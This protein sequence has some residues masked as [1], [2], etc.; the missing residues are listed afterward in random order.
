MAPPLTSC[1][2]KKVESPTWHL[3]PKCCWPIIQDESCVKCW[4]QLL[5]RRQSFKDFLVR[6][7][8][9]LNKHVFSGHHKVFCCHILGRVVTGTLWM[10][11][12]SG[13]R[14]R[15]NNETLVTGNGAKYICHPVNEY[16]EKISVRLVHLPLKEWFI[17]KQF[18]HFLMVFRYD[19]KWNHRHFLSE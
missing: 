2:P 12:N 16:G 17:G 9:L 3:V 7:M 6:N 10:K 14:C 13:S 8:Y 15:E 18:T 4:I 11:S 1:T 19:S 5:E